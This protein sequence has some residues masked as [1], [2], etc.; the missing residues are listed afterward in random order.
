MPKQYTTISEHTKLTEGRDS[1]HYPYSGETESVNKD[2]VNFSWLKWKK[3]NKKLKQSKQKRLIIIVRLKDLTVFQ[4]QLK[5]I[6]SWIRPAKSR[7]NKITFKT[8]SKIL[9]L[10]RN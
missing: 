3:R 7:I 10:I 9:L 4:N 6:F 2:I 8:I 1:K 5:E